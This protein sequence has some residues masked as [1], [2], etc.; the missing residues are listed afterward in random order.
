MRGRLSSL[1]GLLLLGLFGCS[2]LVDTSDLDAGCPAGTKL[3]SGEGC[4]DV[5]DP[6]YGCAL[7][8]C[9]RCPNVQHAVAV[10]DE[11]VC[12]GVCLDGFG[13]AGCSVNLLADE[14]NCGG[15]CEGV[16]PCDYQ[17]A[18]GEFCSNGAC[19]IPFASP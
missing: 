3:C 12:E 1:F 10:C 16:T 6:A 14:D 15:C 18:E 5:D 13:C 2:L 19:E 17:C 4:V 7:D 8:S 11:G 9:T